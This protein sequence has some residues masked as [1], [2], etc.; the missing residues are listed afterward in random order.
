MLPFE[1]KK[2][3][4][5][6]MEEKTQTTIDEICEF[7]PNISNS[8]VRRD[9][10]ILEKEG[11][12][13]IYYGGIIRKNKYFSEQRIENKR[14]TNI[15]AKQRIALY[16]AS[17]VNPEETIFLDS[18]STVAEMIRHLDSSVKVVTT[19][20]DIVLNNVNN[21]DIYLRGGNVS[22]VRNSVYGTS[23]VE[24]L[25]DFV[26]EKAFLGA[27]G[28]SEKFGIT[29]PSKEETMLKHRVIENSSNTYFLIDNSKIGN[30]STCK[31]SPIDENYVIMDNENHLTKV[32]QN[33]SYPEE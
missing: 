17:L 22:K 14:L 29:T 16:A 12:I 10:K 32:Y 30:F 15:S 31:V 8:T 4:E 3:I 19:S 6:L 20:I 26:F 24:Q 9:L 1:R 5:D 21:L 7:L 23:T 33:I 18:G 27:N 13:T 25:K 28:I 11:L 2:K